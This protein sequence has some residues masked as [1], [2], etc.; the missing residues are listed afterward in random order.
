MRGANILAAVGLCC[1][2]VVPGV[3]DPASV[4]K[5]WVRHTIDDSSFGAD[6]ARTADVNGDGL[7]DLV[8]GWEQ[9]GVSRIYLMKREKGSL[10]TWTAVDAGPAPAVEDA[11]LVDLDRDGAMDV[12]SSTE[13]GNKMVLVHWAPSPPADYTDSSLWKTETLFENGSRWMFAVAM[14]IDGKYGPDLVVGGKGKD[15]SVGWLASPGDPR[16]M[17]AW[18]FH[19]LTDVGWIMSMMVKDMDEDGLSDVL[20]SDRKGKDQ[21]V[22]WLKNPGSGVGHW[23]KIWIADDLREAMF[24]D[25]YDLD[26]DGTDEILVPH[27][28]GKAASQLTIFNRHSGTRWARLQV[29]LPE[30][31]TKPKSIQAGDINLDGRPDLVLSTEHA[32]DGSSGIVWLEAGENWKSHGWTVHDISGPEGIK[33]DLNLLLDVDGDGDLDVIN[34]EENNNARGGEGGLGVI[35]YENPYGDR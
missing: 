6:G 14:D 35:W 28:Y 17:K 32:G 9:G 11:L 33:F 7:P 24:I 20:V 23:R 19:K 22:F 5:P 3:G 27:G 30:F 12:V 8:V 29:C 15:A 26:G 16:D 13:G 21:G 10:P 1:S 31:V 18:K 25:A 34:T 2:F 4:P